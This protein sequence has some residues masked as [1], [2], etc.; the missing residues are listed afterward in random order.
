MARYR[1]LGFATAVLLVA[2]LVSAA[3]G[4]VVILKS[5][6]KI[7]CKEPMRIEGPNA[8]LTLATGTL[9]SYPL[10]LV[11]VV[12][13]ERYNQ[14]GL[15]DALMLEELS[16]QGTPIPTPTP[17]TSLG[18]HA[19]IDAAGGGSVSL[20]STIEPTPV[21]T[22][23]IKMQEEEYHDERIEQAF[24]RIFDDK[25]LLIYRTSRGTQAEYFFV[26]TTT[27]SEREVFSALEIVAEAY[28]LINQIHPEIAPSAVELEM[29]QTS[30]KPAGTFRLTPE[31]ANELASGETPAQT[32]YIKNVIF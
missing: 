19:S 20:G 22:P 2:A 11:D 3:S 15:G 5:G 9:A 24:S 16:V 26:Q 8:I 17:Y 14:L 31:L 12:E 18:Q 32:F 4:Y 29:I 10:Q 13:T 27:D 23:G 25:E 1:F 30:G 7:R 6:H 21:P 28:V